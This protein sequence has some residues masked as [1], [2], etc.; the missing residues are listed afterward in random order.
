MLILYMFICM[1]V[2]LYICRG[3]DLGGTGGDGPPQNLRWGGRPMHWSPQYFEKQCCRMC[4][5]V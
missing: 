2:C 1:Y 3:G 4:V 5:K